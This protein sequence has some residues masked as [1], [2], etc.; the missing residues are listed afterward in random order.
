MLREGNH[1][2]EREGPNCVTIEKA[3]LVYAKAKWGE[4]SENV[5]S[6]LPLGF[7]QLLHQKKRV[8]ENG[9]GTE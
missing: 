3:L 5:N 8:L 1:L 6:Y 4:A 2:A 9:Q 7:T